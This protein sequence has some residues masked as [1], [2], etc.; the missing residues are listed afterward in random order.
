[1][2]EFRQLKETLQKMPSFKEGVLAK[3]GQL[4]LPALKDQPPA[5]VHSLS[6]LTGEKVLLITFHSVFPLLTDLSS[7]QFCLSFKM[8]YGVVF[9]VA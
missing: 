7:V 6:P 5:L 9:R 1:M 3:G 2:E 8:Q 4:P